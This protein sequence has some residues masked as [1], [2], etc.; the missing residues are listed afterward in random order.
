MIPHNK[1][2]TED[3]IRLS[4]IKHNGF[5]DYSKTIY[6]NNRIPVIITCP[7]RI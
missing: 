3:F 6:V 5:Y 1:R 4:N 2:S 7:N